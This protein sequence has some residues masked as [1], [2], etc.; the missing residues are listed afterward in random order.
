V[1]GISFLDAVEHVYDLALHTVLLE[2]AQSTEA[3]YVASE[4][5]SKR[6]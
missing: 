2:C 3:G 5:S 4:M 1:A 6:V